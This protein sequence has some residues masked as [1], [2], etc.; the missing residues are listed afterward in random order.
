[1]PCR[2]VHVCVHACVCVCVCVRI[3][4]PA[5]DWV[6]LRCCAG[7]CRVAQG[8]CPD[9]ARPSHQQGVGR[10]VC[11]DRAGEGVSR[12]HGAGGVTHTRTRTHTRCSQA[13]VQ[14]AA[15]ARP[16]PV[17]H[18]RSSLAATAGCCAPSCRARGQRVAEVYAQQ[19]AEVQDAEL[20][21][22]AAT[23][24]VGHMLGLLAEGL[25]AAQVCAAV[26]G[27]VAAARTP[28]H[29]VLCALLAAACLCVCPLD[30]AAASPPPPTHTHTGLRPSGHAAVSTRGCV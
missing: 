5:C 16:L 25:P 20:P 27:S 28:G 3:A 4:T 2:S 19:C 13:H 24:L 8:Q 12:A 23:Q 9:Q 10:P 21:P 18:S 26:G 29:V 17:A 22:A 1:M 6:A 7:D 30:C 15:L 11:G 14:H